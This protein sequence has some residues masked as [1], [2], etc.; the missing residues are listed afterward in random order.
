MSPDDSMSDPDVPPDE[1]GKDE[2]RD[3]SKPEVPISQWQVY[4]QSDWADLSGPPPLYLA[5]DG[6]TIFGVGGKKVGTYNEDGSVTW[7]PGEQPGT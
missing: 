5:E 2:R 3:E 6:K 1:T 4:P 7:E